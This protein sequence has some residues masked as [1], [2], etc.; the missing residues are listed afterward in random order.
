MN[1]LARDVLNLPNVPHGARQR[2]QKR[3]VKNNI[4]EDTTTECSHKCAAA[5]E[6]HSQ[7]NVGKAILAGFTGSR[8]SGLNTFVTNLGVN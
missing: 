8:K 2:K 1:E 5:R 6:C 3:K 7:I 4:S